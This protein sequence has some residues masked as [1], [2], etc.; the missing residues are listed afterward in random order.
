MNPGTP[1]LADLLQSPERI[2][3]LP[4]E[5]VPSF[6]AQLATLQ[7]G[8]YA[9]L[10][11]HPARPPVEAETNE[12]DRWLTAE[13]AAPLIGVTPRWLYNRWK[14]LPF[15]RKLSHKVLRFSE[16]GIR[17]YLAGKAG[18]AVAVEVNR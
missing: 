5:S 10:L 3:E 4:V 9:R 14:Q 12:D 6:L 1:T 8:L 17:R 18:R 13:E 7:S 2:A 16:K 15:S 11:L